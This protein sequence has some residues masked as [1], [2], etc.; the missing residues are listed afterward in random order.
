MKDRAEHIDGPIYD[1]DKQQYTR[2]NTDT[3]DRL[4]PRPDGGAVYRTPDGVV[5]ETN[6]HGLYRVLP[7]CSFLR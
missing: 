5:Y 1:Y 2:A 6:G 7:A 3:D 4:F